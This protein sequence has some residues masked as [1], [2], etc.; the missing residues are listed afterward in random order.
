MESYE[1]KLNPAYS[2]YSGVAVGWQKGSAVIFVTERVL[3]KEVKS[4][5]E[6][7]FKNYVRFVRGRVGC[8]ECFYG[9]VK[10]MFHYAPRM[11]FR[12]RLFSFKR[13]FK[14]EK[15]SS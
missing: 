4:S 10:V 2:L 9:D 1:F 11:N 3:K 6:R 12:S 5:L 15:I 8:P 13:G 7:A 14:N